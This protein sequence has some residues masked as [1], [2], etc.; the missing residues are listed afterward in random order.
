MRYKLGMYFRIHARAW[1]LLP[2]GATIHSSAASNYRPSP[3][4]LWD[5]LDRME[6]CNLPAGSGRIAGFAHRPFGFWVAQGYLA[7]S[8][9][10]ARD[11]GLRRAKVGY[12]STA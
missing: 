3:L 11:T 4:S 1:I 8:L 5:S 12:I 10:A 7:I 2:L 9:T 6:V